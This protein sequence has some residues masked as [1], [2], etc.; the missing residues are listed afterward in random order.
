MFFTFTQAK[1][2]KSKETFRYDVVLKFQRHIP[3]L[4]QVRGFIK[5]RWGVI[6]MLVVGQLQHSHN[7][8]IRLINEEDFATIM[9]RGHSNSDGVP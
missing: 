9:A 1:I 6:S 2:Q 8:L 5:N 4:D 7:I 3:S